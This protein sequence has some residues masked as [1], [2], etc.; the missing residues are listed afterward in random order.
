MNN[1]LLIFALGWLALLVLAAHAGIPAP[2][3]FGPSYAL[4]K[5]P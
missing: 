1:P 5:R 2:E 4:L 3:G